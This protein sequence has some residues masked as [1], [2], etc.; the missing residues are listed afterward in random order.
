MDA[1]RHFIRQN[2]I[3]PPLAFDPRKA[4]KFRRHDPHGEMG[5]ALAAVVAGRTRMAGM[6]RAVVMNDKCAGGKG[7]SKL[8]VDPVGNAHDRDT[9]APQP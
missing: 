8:L 1:A 4:G 5:F 7:G 9:A 2:R 6:V 3:D